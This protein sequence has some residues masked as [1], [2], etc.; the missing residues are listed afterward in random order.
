MSEERVGW[1]GGWAVLSEEGG[2]GV[3]WMGGF[4]RGEGGWGWGFGRL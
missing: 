2:G 1:E 4:K 3:G